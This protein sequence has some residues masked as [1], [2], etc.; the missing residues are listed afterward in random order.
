[1]AGTTYSMR[2]SRVLQKLRAGEVAYCTKLNL[3]DSRAAEIAAMS[4]FD[5]I[6]TDM[7][8]VPNDWSVVEKQ[9][10]AAKVH[11]VDTIVRVARG[12][13]SDYIRPLEMDA[14]GI[15]VP[16][17]M[18]LADAKA[19]IRSTKF[20]PLGLRPVDGGNADGAY[21][22]ID[23][24]DYLSQANEQRFN[25][26]QIEDVEALDELEAIIALPGLD[27]IFFGPGDF[28]QSIGAP[29]QMDHPLLLETRK[30]IAELALKHGK[31]AGTVGA[32]SNC[33]D[34]VAMGYSFISIGA[35]V[36][37]L[38]QYYQNII[39][40]LHKLESKSITSVYSDKTEEGTV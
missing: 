9:I 18:S 35:D 15:M 2:P 5:C 30:K 37:A 38:N 11:G 12:S 21:C 8:H 26:L 23:F 10:L 20:H 29:G 16:H 34:L 31:F 32:V 13:Y 22:N 1:M 6:W 17:I 19:V 28:S 40:Q 24:L 3:G 4:G 25:V 39:G 27:M 36:I 7:E 33:E 14:T